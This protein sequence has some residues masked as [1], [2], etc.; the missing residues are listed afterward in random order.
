MHT[1]IVTSPRGR[2]SVVPLRPSNA[3]GA[4]WV[5]EAKDFALSL[6]ELR[7]PKSRVSTDTT[8]RVVDQNGWPIDVFYKE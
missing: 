2:F 6:V 7:C 4:M 3:I 1:A 8:F 5:A